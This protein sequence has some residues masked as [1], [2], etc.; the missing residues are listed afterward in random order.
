MKKGRPVYSNSLAKAGSGVAPRGETLAGYISKVRGL[1]GFSKAEL[2]RKAKLHFSSLSRIENGETEGKKMRVAVQHNLAT[3]LK[4]PVEYI[5]AACRGVEVDTDQT[6]NVCP[7]CWVPG[8]SPDIRWSMPDAKF[9]LRCGSM[10]GSKC[11][12]CQ[13]PILLTGRFCPECGKPYRGLSR[14]IAPSLL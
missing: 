6:N 12:S 8:T 14:P 5:Q 9:C 11:Q 4:I 13:T 2:A 7:A 10:L 1:R 3:A